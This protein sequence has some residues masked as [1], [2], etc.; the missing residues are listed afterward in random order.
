LALLSEPTTLLDAIVRTARGRTNIIA[1]TYLD[2][3]AG[4]E[5]TDVLFRY[6]S[7]LAGAARGDLAAATHA[8]FAVGGTSGA[9]LALGA[10]LGAWIVAGQPPDL[11]RP[12]LASRALESAWS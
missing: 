10:L 4:G 9:E 2:A 11:I 7:A 12:A 3:A 1:Y 6:I 8:L 5:V